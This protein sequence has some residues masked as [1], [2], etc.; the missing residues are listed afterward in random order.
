MI[1][2][3]KVQ[4]Q[5]LCLGSRTYE[6]CGYQLSYS[7]GENTMP[8]QAAILVIDDELGIREGCRRA[9]AAQDFQV[10]VA[11]NGEEGLRKLKE[12]SFAL[13]LL[14]IMMPGMPGMEVLDAIREAD[15]EIVTIIITG[16]ATVDLAIQ[17]I[18]RGAY[19]FLSKPF[20]TDTLLLAVNQGLEKRRLSLEARRLRQAEEEAKRLEQEKVQLQKLDQLKSQFTLL[21]AHELRAPVAAIQSYLKLILDGYVPQE[22]LME[23]IAKA[24]RRTQDQL[25]LINDLL[26]LA[27]L[28]DEA[29]QVDMSEVDVV[30]ALREAGDMM[31]AQAEGKNIIFDVLVGSG[32][33][34][35]RA[36]PK[37]IKE[38]WNN[39]ISNAIKYTPRG[40]RVTVSL[41]AEG[42]NVVG[43]VRDTGIGIAR[44]DLDRIFQDFYRTK[45]A[46]EFERMGTGLGLSIVKA[47]LDNY[48]GTIRVESKVGKGSVFTFTIPAAPPN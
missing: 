14:D 13:V 1:S 29:K 26:E 43:S 30:E 48:G 45:A 5:A 2:S 38:L 32:I 37:H 24:E 19:D 20:D 16:Y 36:N 7:E 41:K 9:L 34:K 39:L 8:D 27:R 21:V 22:R 10:E 17:A 42:G 31:R 11:E 25:A 28:K 15:P 23:I 40:G 47:I 44:E 4:P 3:T 33:P 18:K 12:R 46:K 6:R 35:I